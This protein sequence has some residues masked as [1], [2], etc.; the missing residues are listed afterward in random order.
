LT[1][2]VFA[3]QTGWVNPFDSPTEKHT[4]TASS[5]HN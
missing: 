4:V 2:N 3:G 1:L 5:G